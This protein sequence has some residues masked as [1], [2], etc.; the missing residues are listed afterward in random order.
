[1][2]ESLLEYVLALSAT[3]IL[4]ATIWILSCA[5][6]FGKIRSFTPE[7]YEEKVRETIEDTIIDKIFELLPSLFPQ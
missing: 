1:M 2:K 7:N 5:R 6:I 4:P 3:L